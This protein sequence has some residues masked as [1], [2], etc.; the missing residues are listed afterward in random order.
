MADDHRT[1][2]GAK[3]RNRAWD[4]DWPTEPR[5]LSDNHTLA[6]NEVNMCDSSCTGFLAS[7]VVPLAWLS[8]VGEAH[9]CDK[10]AT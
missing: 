2:K 3:G 7:L 6:I 4:D 8:T 9:W 10:W 5:A 1:P